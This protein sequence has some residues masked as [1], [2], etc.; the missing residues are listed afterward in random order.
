MVSLSQTNIYHPFPDS[1]AMW[2][3]RIYE[4]GCN[5]TNECSINQYRITGDTI[6]GDRIYH[7]LTK[8]GYLIDQNYQYTFYTEYAGAI[9]QEINNK[10]VFYFPPFSYPQVD[11]LLYDFNLEVG[12]SIPLSYLYPYNFC[13]AIVDT[14]DSVAVGGL[15]RKRFHISTSDNPPWDHTWFIEGIGT[16][17]GLF[18]GFCV[19]WEGWQDLTCFVQD[20]SI[21]Y[22][23]PPNLDCDLITSI[24]QKVDEEFSVQIYPN[25]FTENF[26]I[27]I[28]YVLKNTSVKILNL[29]GQELIKRQINKK[30]NLMEISDFPKG[31]F[32]VQLTNEKNAIIKKVIKE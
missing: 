18:G 25:P 8:S 30:T 3:D 4:P 26:I 21:T 7:K 14:I 9:R 16:E 13:D 31:V 12:D 15:Y 28:P 20:D 11:T 19:P 22:P 6:I 2:T 1:N 27:E 29:E 32:V 24:Y 5:M 23:T 17:Q 10:K